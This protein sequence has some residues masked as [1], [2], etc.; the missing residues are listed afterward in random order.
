MSLNI[1]QRGALT[2]H[3]DLALTILEFLQS[4]KGRDAGR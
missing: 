4:Q 2:G 1:E 3:E